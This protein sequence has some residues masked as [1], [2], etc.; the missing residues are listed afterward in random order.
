[1]IINI[2]EL[3]RMEANLEMS[4]NKANACDREERRGQFW[5][6]V[7]LRKCK[8]ENQPVVCKEGVGSRQTLLGWR[9]FTGSNEKSPWVEGRRKGTACLRE[10]SCQGWGRLNEAIPIILESPDARPVGL[11]VWSFPLLWNEENINTTYWSH[12][13]NSQLT[14]FVACSKHFTKCF[15]CITSF[16]PHSIL[17]R[18]IL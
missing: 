10:Q 15:K 13:N 5:W 1:M 14:E 17:M 3:L 7:V 4:L 12:S 11:Q 2:W 18:S 9:S 16:H 8:K 6:R